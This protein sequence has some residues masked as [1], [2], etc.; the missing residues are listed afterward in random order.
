MFNQ[1]LIKSNK[2]KDFRVARMAGKTVIDVTKACAV[3]EP[4]DSVQSTVSLV[5]R[6][7]IRNMLD[8]R[9]VACY[10]Q[11]TT[12]RAVVHLSMVRAIFDVLL[13][14]DTLMAPIAMFLSNYFEKMSNRTKKVENIAGPGN[15]IHGRGPLPPATGSS[16]DEDIPSKE[17]KFRRVRRDEKKRKTLGSLSPMEKLL[18]CRTCLENTRSLLQSPYECEL[19]D[20]L[21]TRESKF[22]R[23]SCVFR[24]EKVH[25]SSDRRR[26]HD[27]DDDLQ[28]GDDH[29]SRYFHHNKKEKYWAHRK[30]RNKT[31]LK[32]AD[33]H[34][35]FRRTI[36]RPRG[37][38]ST[39]AISD[40]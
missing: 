40:L 17:K 18:H 10:T 24:S 7:V 12:M 16:D 25:F 31:K 19:F 8:E 39:P 14:N 3:K 2:K 23:W 6:S 34:K 27:G 9:V 35:T 37:F 36:E 29:K 30:L 13:E 15:T 5:V 4:Y 1:V 28:G 26:R 32:V 20:L 38:L 21:L 33:H 22:K 11:K